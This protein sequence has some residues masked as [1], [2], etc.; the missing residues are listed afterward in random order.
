ML[1]EGGTVSKTAIKLNDRNKTFLLYFSFD[2]ATD[3]CRIKECYL[4]VE[5]LLLSVNA[6]SHLADNATSLF[7]MPYLIL[8]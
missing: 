2:L 4:S 5:G 1:R 8:K 3:Q 7:T 6:T